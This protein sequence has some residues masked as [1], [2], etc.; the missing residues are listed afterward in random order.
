MPLYAISSATGAAT[1]LGVLCGIGTDASGTEDLLTIAVKGTSP[2][3]RNPAPSPV[4][5]AGLAARRLFPPAPRRA[6]Q[7]RRPG[8]QPPLKGRE[9]SA[10]LKILLPLRYPLTIVNAAGTAKK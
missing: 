1:P 4:L 10:A 8:T 7:S 2:P 9:K 3:R 6:K 5:G